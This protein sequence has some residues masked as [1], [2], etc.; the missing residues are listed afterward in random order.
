MLDISLLAVTLIILWFVTDSHAAVAIGLGDCPDN[1]KPGERWFPSGC[2]ECI[3]QEGSWTCES[4]GSGQITYDPKKCYADYALEKPFPACCI[5]DVR[6]RG[7][8]GFDKNRLVYDVRKENEVALNDAPV[9]SKI[10]KNGVRG[11]N[12]KKNKSKAKKFKRKFTNKAA[13]KKKYVQN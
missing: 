2:Q 7:Q 8:P 13:A 3:C 1:K 9:R 6:C 10:Q 12:K 5:P 4:C 11:G